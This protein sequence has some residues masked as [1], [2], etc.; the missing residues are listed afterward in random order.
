[1]SNDG[2]LLQ[3]VER[4]QRTFI[5]QLGGDIILTPDTVIGPVLEASG[6]DSLDMVELLMASEEEFQ[7]EIPDEIG[8]EYLDIS[9][10]K[11]V[12]EFLV[13]IGVH[14]E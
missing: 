13:A 11:T 8:E 9:G 3:K 12:K 5:E 4:L 2:I 1:M 7:I 10:V 14:K 6:A